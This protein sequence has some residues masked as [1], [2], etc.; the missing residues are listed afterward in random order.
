MLNCKLTHSFHI[1][2]HL[3]M[4]DNVLIQLSTLNLWGPLSHEQWDKRNADWS[5]FTNTG[6]RDCNSQTNK[7]THTQGL[8]QK[9]T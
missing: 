9:N 2:D 8:C 3:Q 6:W 7:H 4:S 1:L 5:S